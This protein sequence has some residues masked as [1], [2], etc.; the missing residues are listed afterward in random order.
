MTN[1]Y[2]VI[3]PL[4]DD[5]ADIDKPLDGSSIYMRPATKSEMVQESE[6]GSYT[7]EKSRTMA[8]R[9]GFVKF[10]PCSLS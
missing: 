10:A 7:A 8:C 1:L 4:F 3:D 6:S 5:G 2:G 9:M